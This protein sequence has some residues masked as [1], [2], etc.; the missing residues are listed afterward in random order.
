MRD[1]NAPL[2]IF[3]TLEVLTELTWQWAMQVIYN[4]KEDSQLWKTRNLGS[5]LFSHNCRKKS[6]SAAYTETFS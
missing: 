1:N 5:E 3:I 4:P 2:P 6:E